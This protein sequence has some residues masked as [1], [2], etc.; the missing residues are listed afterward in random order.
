MVLTEKDALPQTRLNETGRRETCLNPET[1]DPVPNA[2]ARKTPPMCQRSPG[3]PAQL[4]FSTSASIVLCLFQAPHTSY[5]AAVRRTLLERG[6][7]PTLGL[8]YF[9]K[10]IKASRWQEPKK[11]NQDIL[12]RFDWIQGSGSTWRSRVGYKQ[13]LQVP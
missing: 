13:P 10:A 2:H 11:Q 3:H 7:Y 4:R 8:R 9:K 12:K 5:A 6:G 1:S